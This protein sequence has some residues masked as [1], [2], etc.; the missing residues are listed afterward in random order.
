MYESPLICLHTGMPRGDRGGGALRACRLESIT[1]RLG[2]GPLRICAPA[3]M[4][5]SERPGRRARCASKVQVDSKAP[6]SILPLA[7]AAGRGD[8]VRAWAA[9]N[10]DRGSACTAQLECM[11]V[12][13]DKCHHRITRITPIY[14]NPSPQLGR[15]Y[16]ARSCA[17]S[18]AEGALD[19]QAAAKPK[20]PGSCDDPAPPPPV[21]S[22]PSG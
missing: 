5:R 1:G 9:C 8:A 3:G 4:T 21:A 16:V 2:H 11:H 12:L 20:C 14:D 17:G 6:G 13:S 15:Q 10:S 18:C 19:A 7:R 22:P